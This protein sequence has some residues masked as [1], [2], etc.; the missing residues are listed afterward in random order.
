MQLRALQVDPP[1]R[2]HGRPIGP[3]SFLVGRQKAALWLQNSQYGELACEECEDGSLKT[4]ET[5]KCSVE[6][7]AVPQWSGC[8]EIS[9]T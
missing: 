4:Q 5:V 2:F 9:S 1:V 3:F 7:K 8:C 6:N